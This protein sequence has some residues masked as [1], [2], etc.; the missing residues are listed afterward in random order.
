MDVVGHVQAVWK[1]RSKLH[2]QPVRIIASV[3]RRRLLEVVAWKKRE[4]IAH[5]LETGDLILGREGSHAAAF[6][7]LVAAEGVL[8]NS[9]AGDALDHTRSSDEHVG[10]S[11]H[12]EDEV[13]QSRRVGRASH[14]PSITLICGMTPDAWVLRRNTPP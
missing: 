4:Q 5:V 6:Q 14:G 2:A 7:H 1:N 3:V 10:Q 13:G 12:G 11:A 8:R 9:L